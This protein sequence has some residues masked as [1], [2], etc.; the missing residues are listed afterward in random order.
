MSPLSLQTD[1][2]QTYP[3]MTMSYA[4]K[5]FA[6]VDTPALS[7]L[8][9]GPFLEWIML[10]R[11]KRP[12]DNTVLYT[13]LAVGSVFANGSAA[14]AHLSEFSQIGSSGIDA[15]GGSLLHLMLTTLLFANLRHLQGDYDGA[16]ELYISVYKMG[17]RELSS[18][19]A[20]QGT[21]TPPWAFGLDRGSMMECAK[22]ATWLADVMLC[23]G[24]CRCPYAQRQS[25]WEIQH[26][27]QNSVHDSLSLDGS[28]V[29]RPDLILIATAL[30]E[31]AVMAGTPRALWQHETN[32]NF[33]TIRSRL[34][35][36]DV[37]FQGNRARGQVSAR[38]SSA[39]Q[40]VDILYFFAKA[41]LHRRACPPWSGP[42]AQAHYA[43]EAFVNASKI[44]R[45]AQQLS[46]SRTE[47]ASAFTMLCPFI[48]LA[49]FEAF[50]IITAR[51]TMYHLHGEESRV[52]SMMSAGL[53]TLE[54]LSQSWHGGREQ[55]D[56]AK[57]RMEIMLRMTLPNQNGNGGFYFSKSMQASGEWE[58]D[59][60]YSC[61]LLDYFDEMDWS[62]LIQLDGNFCCLD[63]E[64]Q[65]MNLSLS[66]RI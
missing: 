60:M 56:S 61:P 65:Q 10:D 46:N 41:L 62:S 2:Y 47:D 32:V 17:Q 39:D 21:A 22:R 63:G 59:V 13:V 11:S 12:R 16:A 57:K 30:R 50:D 7:V 19:P 4:E 33:E 14:A 51:G 25:M 64:D 52:M 36:W 28:T 44:L 18:R 20:D 23:L 66:W 48:G 5:Y 6:H 35:T 26:A 37:A 45:V 9:K 54:A 55:L 31:V 27:H 34:D 29:S 1:L 8:P 49:I 40:Q 38:R 43:H 3:E 15:L 42:E 53:E 58:Q 24:S